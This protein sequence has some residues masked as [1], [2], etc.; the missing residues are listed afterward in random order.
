THAWLLA[1]LP[2]IGLAAWW[3]FAQALALFHYLLEA[4]LALAPLWQPPHEH[5]YPLALAWL[6]LALGWGLP[7]TPSGVRILVTLLA[8]SAPWWPSERVEERRLV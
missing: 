4:S 5:V 1:P 7:A 6:L 3:V 8:L 2:G